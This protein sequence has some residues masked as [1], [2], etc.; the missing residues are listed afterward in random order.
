[1]KFRDDLRNTRS[2]VYLQLHSFNSSRI[3]ELLG[4]LRG[5]KV[6]IHV[7]KNHKLSDWLMGLN[8]DN[9]KVKL[10]PERIGTT[11]VIL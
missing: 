7:S 5:K 10:V 11:A 2:T 1:E 3:Q 9:L 4:L 6:V 8:S